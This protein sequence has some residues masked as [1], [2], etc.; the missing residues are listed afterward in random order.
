MQGACVEL[1][2]ARCCSVIRDPHAVV[3]VVDLVGSRHV[4]RGAWV[5]GA[6][7]SRSTASGSV[8]SAARYSTY[9]LGKK[10]PP[11]LT[12]LPSKTLYPPHRNVRSSK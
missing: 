10:S 7:R 2:Q 11:T 9:P 8:L 5:T 4:T 6:C 12:R 1:Q 3:H